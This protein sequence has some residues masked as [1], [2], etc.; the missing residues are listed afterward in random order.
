MSTTL[1]SSCDRIVIA[2]DGSQAAEWAV[3]VGRQLATQLS[4][5]VI[6]VHV[7][8]PV[9]ALGNDF[10]TEQ[11]VEVIEREQG[12]DLLERTRLSFPSCF[13]VET[14]LRTGF[15]SDQIAAVARDWKA[16]MIVMGTRG[17]NRVA[18]F[19]LGS[20]A[21]TVIRQSPCPV[22]TVAH[23]PRYVSTKTNDWAGVGSDS[24][25]PISAHAH[26]PINEAGGGN[27]PN[28]EPSNPWQ[29]TE[30]S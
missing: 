4:A 3:Q 12:K 2:I 26:D 22:V 7:V 11:Q 16:D 23:E 29:I 8:E 20:T 15:P 21:E 1:S 18:Q 27:S 6:L 5:Q 28:G 25:D 9:T 10:T 13:K 30:V 17:R 24:A 19:V 14:S